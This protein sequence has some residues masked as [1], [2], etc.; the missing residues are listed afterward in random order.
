MH[1]RP[2]A[3][4]APS[5]SDCVEVVRA[6][7]VDGER[8]LI[9]DLGSDRGDDR[10]VGAGLDLA[11]EPAVAGGDVRR[12][13]LAQLALVGGDADRDT[14]GDRVRSAPARVGASHDRNDSPDA[15]SSRVQAG[16]L[17][18]ALGE[19]VAPHVGEVVRPRTRAAPGGRG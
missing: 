13:Q 8:D 17:D 15:R 6:V 10:D 3:S 2:N 1:W 19:V 16:D 14:R 7:R 18:R 11:L 9:A 5:A 12:R 4:S